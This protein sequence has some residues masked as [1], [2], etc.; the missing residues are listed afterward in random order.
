MI[1]VFYNLKKLPFQK[2]IDTK[3]IFIYSSTTEVQRRLEYI[4][5]KR[6]IM[7][8]TG[9][10][11]VGK[12][13]QVRVFV[14]KLN[15]NLFKTIY[16]PLSTVNVIDFYRQ[17]SLHLCGQTFWKKSDLFQSIQKTIQN[18]VIETKKIPVIIFDEAHLLK[19]EN[20]L[21]LQIITNFNIDSKDPALFILIG[22]PHLRDRF[23][24][25]VLRPFNQRNSLKYNLSPL[26]REETESYIQH[27]LNIAGLKEPLFNPNA[28]NTIYQNSN[29]IPRVINSICL[30][31]MTIEA[32]ERKEEI[33]E[34]EIHRASHEL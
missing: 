26:S 22:Q 7:L 24:Y 21:K 34:E 2:D 14:E 3:E 19:S 32:I 29:G 28:I 5:Q 1:E 11:G 10:S 4:K 27:H 15:P 31:A 20:F 23:V 25:P 6:G 8:I 16:I 13:L 33:T 9:V 30:K 18:Y 12:T 17:L